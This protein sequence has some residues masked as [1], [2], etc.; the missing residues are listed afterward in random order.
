MKINLIDK[1]QFLITEFWRFKM[2]Y[3]GR[4]GTKSWA[5]ADA[6][7]YL[8]VAF[9][10]KVR[11]ILCTRELQK[12]I[13]ES[14]HKLISDRISFHQLDQLFDI[15]KTEINCKNGSH[16]IFMGLRHNSTEIKP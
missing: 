11:R 15:T 6:L 2:L 7:L 9:P 4:G 5:I 1:L 13:K 10:D 16:F 12:S 3:G 8:I 14:V